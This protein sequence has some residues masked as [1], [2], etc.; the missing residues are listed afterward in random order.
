MLEWDEKE[1]EDLVDSKL[2]SSR[3]SF[4]ASYKQYFTAYSNYYHHCTHLIFLEE[5]TV[6]TA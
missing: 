4:A 5:E 1:E 2:W 6:M 3:I